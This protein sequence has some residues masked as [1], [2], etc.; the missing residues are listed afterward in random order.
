[1]FA[2]VSNFEDGFF[3]QFRRLENE[4]EQVFGSGA[5]P[6]VAQATRTRSAYPPITKTC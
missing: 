1:M 2:R 3:D 6:Q 4:M 5:W